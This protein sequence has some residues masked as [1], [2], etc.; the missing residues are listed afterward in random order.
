MYRG[1]QFK[2]NWGQIKVINE[3]KYSIS[4]AG[5]QRMITQAL[6]KERKNAGESKRLSK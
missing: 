3:E 1:V 2:R 6:G 4:K 5:G